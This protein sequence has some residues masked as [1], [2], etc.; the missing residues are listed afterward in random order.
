MFKKITETFF[1]REMTE[2]KS[3]PVVDGGKDAADID[4]DAPIPANW[5]PQVDD[6]EF[7]A[8]D[9]DMDADG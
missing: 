1:R 4:T 3:A 8:R 6:S 9:K 5:K 2:V 7:E